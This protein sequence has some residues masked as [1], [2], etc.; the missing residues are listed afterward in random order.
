MYNVNFGTEQQPVM[1]NYNKETPAQSSPTTQT[2]PRII[3]IPNNNQPVQNQQGRNTMPAVERDT[4][5]PAE[6]A[7]PRTQ[8]PNTPQRTPYYFPMVQRQPQ[9]KNLT[10]IIFTESQGLQHQL[11]LRFLLR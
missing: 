5:S 11:S 3:V 8:T 4:F 7:A 2:Q 1:N 10:G 9:K 6:A